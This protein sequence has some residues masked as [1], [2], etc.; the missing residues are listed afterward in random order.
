MAGFRYDEP[1]IRAAIKA[2]QNHRGDPAGALT[3]A[4]LHPFMDEAVLALAQHTGA[5]VLEQLQELYEADRA[6]VARG[7][8]L[9]TVEQHFA[10]HVERIVTD[11]VVVLV[12]RAVLLG[13][14]LGEGAES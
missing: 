9:E 2:A 6:A 14:A 1:A 10:S 4:G 5:R 7:E 3:A 12:Q 8:G 13:L 11:P